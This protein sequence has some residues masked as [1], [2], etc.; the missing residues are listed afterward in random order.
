MKLFLLIAPSDEN[1]KKFEK[2]SLSP[3]QSIHFFADF[4]QEECYPVLLFPG[5]TFF[6]PSGWIHAVYTP[7]DSLVFGGNFLHQFATE[8]Q[9]RCWTIENN[10]KIPTKFRFPMFEKM[11]WYAASHFWK[12]LK[13]NQYSLKISSIHTKK[14][15]N[16]KKMKKKEQIRFQNWKEMES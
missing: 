16:K 12:L 8:M 4:V 5:Q 7:I 6:I 2:W 1:L 10:T 15:P 9:L 11:Q 3:T 13:G 14:K